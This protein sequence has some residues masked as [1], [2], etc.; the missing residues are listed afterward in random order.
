M[1]RLEVLGP[2]AQLLSTTC[3]ACPHNA[4]GCCVS[5]PDHGW[6]DVGR[7]VLGGGRAFLLEQIAAR[8]LVPSAR[9]LAVRRVRGRTT[10]LAPRQK[11][12]VYHGAEGCTIAASHRPSTCNYFLCD[13]AYREAGEARGNPDAV[14]AR[15]AQSAL[16]ALHTEW[17]QEIGEQIAAL[18]PEGP[19][20]DAAFLDWLGAAIEARMG[21]ASRAAARAIEVRSSL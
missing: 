11:K 21:E 2:Q 18:F 10:S 7:L 9:G 17:N 12:C 8:N 6:A 19:A 13:D 20:W 15:R 4:A 1:I 16:A 3:A 14:A 5:P